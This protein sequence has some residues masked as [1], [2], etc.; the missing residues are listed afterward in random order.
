MDSKPFF[1]IIHTEER[2]FVVIAIPDEKNV[3][4][5]YEKSLR[6][7]L[8][9][10]DLTETKLVTGELIQ[11]NSVLFIKKKGDKNEKHQYV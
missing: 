4:K 8:E 6:K 9:N 2:V 5:S 3:M 1:V 7:Y 11:K 10:L